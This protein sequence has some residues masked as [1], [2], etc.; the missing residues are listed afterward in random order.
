MRVLIGLDQ[1]S[2]KTHAVV[3]DLNGHLLALGHAPGSLHTKK[4]M[5]DA[6]LR[7]REAAESAL[8]G[9]GANWADVVALSG[10]LTGIDYPF[11]QVLLT[12]TLRE[13]FGIEKV[14]VHNDCIGALWGG[15]FGGPAIVCCAG[16]GLNLGGVNAEGELYQLGNYANGIYQ[17][18]S[19]IGQ[20]GLQ[21]VFDARIRKGPGTRLTEL[22]LTAL[23]LPDVDELLVQRYRK[24]GVR[25]ATLCPLVF[26]A[27]GQGDAVAIR[28][29]EECGQN[30]AEFLLSVLYM[31]R[32]DP[33]KP[34]RAILSGSVFKGKPEI[35]RARIEAVLSEKAP[36]A[37]IAD[38]RYEPIVGGAVMG[39]FWLGEGNWQ[40]NIARSAETLGL[41]RK[42][43]SL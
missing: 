18:A 19:S 28:I 43:E 23:G 13:H 42:E 24:D 31:L 9:A 2:T 6:L 22:F 39:L 3:S 16:T 4:G 15:T 37:V 20:H 17:G 30:W 41:L 5:P 21:A 35:P 8:K 27:A 40:E 1:G 34:V 11:E 32:I 7:M 29:L 38:A 33:A 25:V 10:G 14:Y 26:E 12:E 36:G